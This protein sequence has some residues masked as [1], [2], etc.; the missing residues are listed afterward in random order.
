[1][2]FIK[3]LSVYI[4]RIHR[5]DANEQFI[6]QI[7]YD[8]EIA[9]VRRIDFIK[10]RDKKYGGHH[11]YQAKIY[12]HYWFKNQTAYNVQQRILNTNNVGA[13]V[14][15]NDPWYW[16]V[17]KNANPMTEMELC[18]NERLEYLEKTMTRQHKKLPTIQ[19]EV[20]SLSEQV[21][22][23]QSDV[24]FL[25]EQARI[26]IPQNTHIRFCYPEH[27][28][29][30][31]AYAE[32]VANSEAVAN[33]HAEAVANSCAEAVLKEEASTPEWDQYYNQVQQDE[34]DTGDYERAYPTWNRTLLKTVNK[35]NYCEGCEL[36]QNGTGGENQLQH[37]CM[38]EANGYEV[39][40]NYC[41]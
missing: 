23:L 1:M 6:K 29:V 24:E 20:A 31:N 32:A 21:A 36:L 37:T 9:Y 35:E 12:F 27:D 18:V 39:I 15:Y 3:N 28:A 40:E 38:E 14:M 7:F 5:E 22:S 13:R 41:F 11:Y 17:L 19:E 25:K 34:E 8:Q 4:P 10:K 33:A 16:V 2:S 26:K 30:A